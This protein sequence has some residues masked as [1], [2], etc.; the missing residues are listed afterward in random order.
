MQIARM[1]LPGAL[2][3]AQICD[4]VIKRQGRHPADYDT[5]A[6]SR[7]C[8]QFT[9]AEIE[10]VFVDAPHEV[11]SEGKEPSPKDIPQAMSNDVPLANLMDF[12]VSAAPL[13]HRPRQRSHQPHNICPQRQVYDGGELKLFSPQSVTRVAAMM[14]HNHHLDT[15]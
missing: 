9:G 1:N 5:V 4:I 7:A 12:Q 2:E 10:A 15:P 6:L 14:P 13:G 11:F 8:E 3:C